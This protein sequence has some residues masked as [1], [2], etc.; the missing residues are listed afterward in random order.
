MRYIDI[1][2][3]S[4]KIYFTHLTHPVPSQPGDSVPR[5]SWGKYFTEGERLKMPV[6]VQANHAVMDGLHLGRYFLNFQELLDHPETFF[7]QS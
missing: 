5:V 7:G 1:E 2:Q 6:H 4:R 3:W